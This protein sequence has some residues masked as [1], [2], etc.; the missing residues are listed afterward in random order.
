MVNYDLPWNPNRLEQR[1]GRIH[2]IGQ[3]EVCHLWNLLA[4]DTREGEVY[5]QLLEKLDNARKALGDK[6]FDVLGQ[7][8]TGR[9]LRELL[10]DAVRYN[11]D[12]AVKARMQEIDEAVNSDHLL[13]L[14]ER[15]ALVKQGMDTSKVRDLRQQMERAMARRIHPH[16]VH[17]FFLEA[18]RRLG[19]KAFPREQGRYEITHV[20]PQLL[21]RDQ[22]I[23][24]GVPVQPR[25][26]R[27]CFENEHVGQSPRAELVSPGHPLL[28]ACISLIWERHGEVLGQGAVLIDDQDPGAEPRLL[29]CLEHGLQDGRKNRQ[30]QQQLISNR[31]QFLEISRSGAA[32]PA[33]SAP[34]LDY[35]PL[36]DGERE[37][38]QPL[39]GDDWLNQDWDQLVLAHAMQTLVPEHLEEIRSERLERI[40]KARQ[41]IQA[42]LQR[43]INHWSRQYE[44]LKHKDSAGKKTRLPAQV[45]KERAELLVNRLGKRMAALDAEAQ[46]SA[47]VPLI[48]GGALIVPAGLLRQIRGETPNA[49]VDADAKKRV[50]LLAMAAVF[51]A[52][53]AL[54]RIPI[55]R[56]EQR[57][58]GY[59]IES[60]APDG[61]LVFIEVKGRVEG[62]DSVT[63]T[64]NE[65]KCGNNKPESFRLAISTISGDQ[66]SPPR[67]VSGIDWGRPGFGSTGQNFSLAQL[68]SVAEGPH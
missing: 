48:K 50:D 32:K 17:D 64:T 3:Q 6:V 49:S 55:D 66:A 4:Q 24:V 45:A 38:I 5:I 41:E 36:R 22:Q 20:S 34:Y 28:E 30:G 40:E 10:M 65:L 67:Y 16:Y 46:I 27:I 29:V 53:R 19:G 47:R 31:L 21:D 33:G 52:E 42:R 2:R 37:L 60:A 25:Y 58:I 35:R 13:E 61:T 44:E 26:E 14:L 7:L 15:R 43:Q 39:L 59:D 9:S 11:A 1:F 57:G 68:L 12:P 18:F 56:S 62:A 63:V 51:A 23:G 8:F 54:G